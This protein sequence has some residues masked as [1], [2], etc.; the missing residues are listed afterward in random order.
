MKIYIIGGR[1]DYKERVYIAITFLLKPKRL[2][3]FLAFLLLYFLTL[4]SKPVLQFLE[5]G[6]DTKFHFENIPQKDFRRK[7]WIKSKLYTPSI[8]D[9]I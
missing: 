4:K 8:F 3:I 1:R 5:K 9:Y 7:K 2:Q 6:S